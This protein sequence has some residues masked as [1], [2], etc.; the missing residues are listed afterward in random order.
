[1]NVKEIRKLKGLDR[2][3]AVGSTDKGNKR[4]YLQRG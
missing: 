1:M 4:E 3:T 2:N